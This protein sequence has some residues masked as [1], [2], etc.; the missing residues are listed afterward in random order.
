VAAD[1]TPLERIPTGG[2]ARSLAVS[3]V[4][5]PPSSSE[6]ILRALFG[7]QKNCGWCGLHFFEWRISAHGLCSR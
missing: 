2:V 6:R 4:T 7:G 3:S 1:P 5:T